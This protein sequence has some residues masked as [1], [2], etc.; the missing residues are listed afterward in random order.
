GVSGEHVMVRIGEPN[1]IAGVALND[2]AD[3]VIILGTAVSAPRGDTSPGNAQAAAD[4]Q[5]DCVLTHHVVGTA[6][7]EVDAVNVAH[8]RVT[9]QRGPTAVG[10]RDP[11]PLVIKDSIVLDQ[12]VKDV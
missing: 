6:H 4:V 1:P 8:N 11:V 3:E 10:H 7:A 9:A 5:G 2:I 12:S